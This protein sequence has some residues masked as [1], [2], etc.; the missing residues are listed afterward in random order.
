MT[1]ILVPKKVRQL[2][3]QDY[4]KEMNAASKRNIKRVRFVPPKIGKED[5][6]HFEITYKTPVLV[7]E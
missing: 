3:A 5:F 1:D 4:L 7:A 6:G 2:S